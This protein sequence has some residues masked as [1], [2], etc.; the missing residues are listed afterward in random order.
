MHSLTPSH[1]FSWLSC[2]VSGQYKGWDGGDNKCVK[3]V[4]VPVFHICSSWKHTWHTTQLRW[5]VVSLCDD[6]G[7]GT[8]NFLLTLSF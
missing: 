7:A 4:C 5:N 2:K 6:A 1:L 3:C 8:L